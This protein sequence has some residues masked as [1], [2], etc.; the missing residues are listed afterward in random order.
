M[1]LYS[2]PPSFENFRCAIESHDKLPSPEVFQINIMEESKAQKND[3]RGAVQN[4][5]MAKKGR[6]VNKDKARKPKSKNKE[7]FKFRC[8]R[9][10][11]K[12]HKAAD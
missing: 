2:L 4:A 10:K 9:C 3:A 11:E 8:H 7:E 5:L 6:Y 1:L 12:G